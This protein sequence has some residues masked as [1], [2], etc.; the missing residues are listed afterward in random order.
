MSISIESKIEFK[1][2]RVRKEFGKMVRGEEN[3]ALLTVISYAALISREDL[4]VT[5]VLTMIYRTEA[6]QLGLVRIRNE[7]RLR[8]GLP[9]IP[10]DRMSVHQL[11]RGFDLR[12]WVYN[13]NQRKHL[14]DRVNAR[15]RYR[16][17]KLVLEFHPRGTAGHLHGQIPDR[18]IWKM[19]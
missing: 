4:D 8:D 11:W 1:T 16:N 6:E 19:S 14:C 15:F 10:E 12:S 9:L 3:D 18:Q 7:Q 5:P 17:K 13:D 2:E